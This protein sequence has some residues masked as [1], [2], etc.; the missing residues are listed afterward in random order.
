MPRCILL[1]SFS[2]TSFVISVLYVVWSPFVATFAVLKG[3]KK[4][5]ILIHKIGPNWY[6][7]G[8]KSCYMPQVNN[9]SVE[10]GHLCEQT[11]K[12]HLWHL[13]VYFTDQNIIQ[14]GKPMELNFEGLEMQKWNIPTD[15][16][17]KVDKENGVICLVT[18]FTPGVVVIKMAKIAHFFYF[19][20]MTAK[21]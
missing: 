16:A 2:D 20:M 8:N 4:K 5:S 12:Y 19:L 1:V 6:Q 13:D 21:S 3:I 15:R 7:I 9:F 18:R 14:S 11:W 17:Q 10:K